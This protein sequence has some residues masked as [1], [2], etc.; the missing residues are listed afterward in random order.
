MLLN[1]VKVNP[2]GN[3]TVYILDP[4]PREQYPKIAQKLIDSSNLGCEQVGFLEKSTTGSNYHLHMAGGEFCGNAARGM[5]TWLAYR[6]YPYSYNRNGHIIVPLEV[7]GADKILMVEVTDLEQSHKK[8]AKIA[9]P[10]PLSIKE[11]AIDSIGSFPVVDL[12]GISHAVLSGQEPDIKKFHQIKKLL[13]E[14]RGSLEAMGVMFYDQEKQEITPI[15]YVHEIGSLIWE[16]S[17][18]SGTVSVGCVL[19][20][21]EK[22]SVKELKLRQPGGDLFID[23]IWQDGIKETYLSGEIEIVAEGTVFVDL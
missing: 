3:M 22:K 10:L 2:S 17:C 8:Y 21:K 15:V 12:G 18:G 19:A 5:A 16:Q 13:E 11:Y 7:S 9:M 20:D 4:L 14:D 6:Q 23:V 1:F